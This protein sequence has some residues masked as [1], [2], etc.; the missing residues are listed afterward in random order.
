MS[1]I[2]TQAI[3]A[4]L[5]GCAARYKINSAYLF[6]SR[7]RE[8]SEESSDI[9]ICIECDDGFNLF[10][11]GGLGEH[12]EKALGLPVDIVCGEAFFYPKARER[13]LKDRVL[14]Y[15]KS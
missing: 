13:Y 9:D 6:G 15:A 8:S 10:M 5:R 1:T 7:A 12:L 14:L 2:S 11:L 3:A 4:T